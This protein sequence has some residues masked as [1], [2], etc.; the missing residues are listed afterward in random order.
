M[1]STIEP[2]LV[3]DFVIATLVSTIV[4]FANITGPVVEESAGFNG[5]GS[6]VSAGLT[7]AILS[8]ASALQP[9]EI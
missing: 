6:L 1:V 9:S 4:E 5:A 8:S 2:P 7:V 3:V